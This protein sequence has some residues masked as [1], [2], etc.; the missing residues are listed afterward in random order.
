MLK[1]RFLEKIEQ[2]GECWIWQAAYDVNGY[3]RFW[4]KDRMWPAHRAAYDIFVEDVGEL[5]VLHSCVNPGCVNPDHLRLGTHAEN[6][7]DLAARGNNKIQ[8]I[9]YPTAIEMRLDGKSLQQIADIFGCSKA[10][11][12]Q[13][14]KRHGY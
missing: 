5:H 8:K 11:V 10:A 1:Q 3:G 14:L 12:S 9:H 6:M 13:G 2:L 4:Y 7:Q